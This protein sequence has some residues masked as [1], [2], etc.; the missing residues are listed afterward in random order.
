MRD[1]LGAGW[2]CEAVRTNRKV[3]GAGRPRKVLR[4]RGGGGEGAE[5]RT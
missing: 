5:G 1:G 2:R 4:R 3:G